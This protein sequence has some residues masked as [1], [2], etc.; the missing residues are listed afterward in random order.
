MGTSCTCN[1]RI[2]N[3]HKSGGYSVDQGEAIVTLD[4][5]RMWLNDKLKVFM[6]ENSLDY[7][8]STNSTAAVMAFNTLRE[9]IKTVTPIEGL[10]MQTFCVDVEDSYTKL[11][12]QKFQPSKTIKEGYA[13][14][15]PPTSSCSTI[16]CIIVGI[17]LFG[18]AVYAVYKYINCPCRKR[19]EKALQEALDST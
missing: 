7:F 5:Q 10:E 8:K 17:I 2:C 13:P 14:I 12:A 4:K 9:N 19:N 18:L 6:G 1:A 16:I 11:N 3:Y 15:N